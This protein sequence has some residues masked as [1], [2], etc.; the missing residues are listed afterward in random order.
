MTN[1]DSINSFTSSDVKIDNSSNSINDSNIFSSIQSFGQDYNQDG[2]ILKKPV[3]NKNDNINFLNQ[4]S[5]IMGSK[6]DYETMKHCEEILKILAIRFETLV[7]S[8]HR[9]PD[10]MFQFAKTAKSRGIKVIIAAAGG[11]AH[12]PGMVASLTELPVIG[13]PIKSSTLLGIDSLLSI[14]Q[15]PFGVPVAT[16][17]IGESGAKNAAILAAKMLAIYNEEIAINVANFTS[18]QAKQVPIKPY[19]EEKTF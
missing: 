13:V 1:R 9:T 18:K 11:A 6:S 15:M 16:V 7:I 4:V 14:V 2:G 10:R 5:V 17:A 19:E 12:L 3:S 8:A